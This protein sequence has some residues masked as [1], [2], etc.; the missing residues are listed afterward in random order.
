MVITLSLAAPLNL[1]SADEL[2]IKVNPHNSGTA[3]DS[4]PQDSKEVFISPSM[5]YADVIVAAPR[6]DKSIVVENNA[7]H[8]SITVNEDDLTGAPV[9][10]FID[11]ESRR[12][13]KSSTLKQK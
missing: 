7:M 8:Q 13:T 4:Y 12:D 3:G 6:L 11:D 2:M 5:T 9:V 1:V 10:V